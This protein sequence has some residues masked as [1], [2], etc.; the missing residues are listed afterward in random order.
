MRRQSRTQVGTMKGGTLTETPRGPL[1]KGVAHRR[2]AER[3]SVSITLSPLPL[4]PRLRWAGE[5]P[6]EAG[7]KGQDL[8]RNSFPVGSRGRGWR[9]GQVSAGRSSF[10]GS[11]RRVPLVPKAHVTCPGPENDRP[12]FRCSVGLRKDTGWFQLSE[13]G[14]RPDSG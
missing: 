12:Y 13:S 3:F 9:R 11:N 5:V 6:G 4:Q 1:Q 7:R 14:D 8:P 2:T 10:Q